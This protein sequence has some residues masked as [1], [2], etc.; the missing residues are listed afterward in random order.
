[1]LGL[2][3]GIGYHFLMKFAWDPRKAA[4]NLKKHGVS[5]DEAS[6][7]FGDPLSATV[8]DPDHSVGERRFI[9]MGV[10]LPGRLLVA[11]HTEE[12]GIFRIISAR[13]A[14]RH[15]KDRYES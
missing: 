11:C 7:I 2:R 8:P 3:T 9:T 6:T 13:R 4:A 14:T 1:V 15:E 10:S 5:F 12:A